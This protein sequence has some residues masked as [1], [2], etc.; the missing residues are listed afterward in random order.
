MVA[1][2]ARKEVNMLKLKKITKTFS[3]VKVLEK[4]DLHIKRGEILVLIGP[5]GSG[6]TTLLNIIAELEKIDQGVIE[7]KF[8]KVGYVFQEDRL[9][10]WLSVKDN[11][12]IVSNDT[13][14]V[15]GILK[16]L[17]IWDYA[18]NLPKDLSG[19]MKQRVSIA[20]AYNFSSELVLMDEP[21]KCLDFKLKSELMDDLITK[22]K[23][24]NNTYLLVTHDEKVAAKLATRI[25]MLSNKPVRVIN[26]IVLEK[27]P[28]SRSFEDIS[29]I[30]K[31]ILGDENYDKEN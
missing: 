16:T 4:F 22:W 8:S 31:I 5:S 15:E 28:F 17:K 3:K 29:E 23:E 2:I 9:L 25:L 30:E 14:K 12:S 27:K 1:S 21:F 26:E 11:V 20:R 18:D 13:S 6:K 19:G 10:P 24:D 7:K